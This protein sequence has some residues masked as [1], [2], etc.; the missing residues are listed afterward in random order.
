MLHQLSYDGKFLASE[1]P[2]LSEATM[3]DGICSIRGTVVKLFDSGA[4]IYMLYN[5]EPTHGAPS[6]KELDILAK[7][8]W[9]IW[10]GTPETVYKPED[11]KSIIQAV[12]NLCYAVRAVTDPKDD[13]GWDLVIE[14]FKEGSVP[15]EDHPKFIGMTA[16][17]SNTMALHATTYVEEVLQYFGC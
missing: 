8:Y 6:H 14:R 15:F 1:T 13:E 7:A 3:P 11:A 17:L 5:V 4:E 12:G 16:R 10:R 9:A 2:A